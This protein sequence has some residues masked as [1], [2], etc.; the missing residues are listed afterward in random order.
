VQ[1][2]EVPFVPPIIRAAAVDARGSLWISFVVPFTYVYDASG[3]KTRT[4]QFS[5]AGIIAPTSL[6]F[7]RDGRLLVTPGCYEFDPR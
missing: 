6:A 3:D 7:G 2:R 5:A 4:V 1:D